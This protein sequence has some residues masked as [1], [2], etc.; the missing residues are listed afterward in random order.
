MNGERGERGES[1][2]VRT[3]ELAVMDRMKHRER[4]KMMQGE[5]EGRTQGGGEAQGG[6][7][8]WRGE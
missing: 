8:D 2:D 4:E 1:R 6:M 5:T 3:E 7:A